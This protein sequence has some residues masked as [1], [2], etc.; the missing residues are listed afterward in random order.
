MNREKELAIN[1]VVLTIGKIC[2]QFISFVL[3]PLYTAILSTSDFGTFDL[4]QTYATLLLPIVSFNID[5]GVLRFLLIE[6]DSVDRQKIL[7]STAFFAETLLML[8]F[9]FAFGVLTLLSGLQYAGFLFATVSLN[10]LSGLLQ[11]IARGIGK[12]IVYT[13]A[14]VLSAAATVG[15]N[16][17]LIAVFRCGIKGLFWGLII[18]QIVCIAYLVIQTHFASFI[19][20]KRFD[21]CELKRILSYSAPL[22]PATISWWVVGASDRTI[23]SMVLGVAMNGAY[24]V[25][26]KFSSLIATFYN[27]FNMAWTESVVLHFHDED[28]NDFLSSTMDSVIMLFGCICSTM[29]AAMPIIYPIMVNQSYY[30]AYNQIPILTLSVLFQVVTGLY[31]AVYLSVNKTTESAKTAFLAAVINIVTDLLLIKYIGLYA[32]SVS[33]LVAY[34]AMAVY[35]HFDVKKY[36]TIKLKMSHVLQIVILFFMV[37]T[38]YYINHTV[39]SLIILLIDIVFCLYGNRK[40]VKSI[41]GKLKENVE[42]EYTRF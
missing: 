31:S 17:L 13:K 26:N 5:Q 15:S 14:S 22:V 20:V 11:Q 2:T 10:V 23:V 39:L 9:G 41:L 4:M 8:A 37:V 36:C 3:L 24:S 29:L 32:A 7:V 21:K 16:V 25:A 33:T 18:G 12:T 19:S 40:L 34:F 42:K 27:V 1:T 30:Q 6:R 38:A 28:K 35:R